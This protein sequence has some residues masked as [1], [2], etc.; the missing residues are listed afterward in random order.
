MEEHENFVRG[1][2][3]HGRDWQTIAE[4]FVPTRTP[5]QIRTHAQKY[6]KKLERAMSFS[7][8]VGS[9]KGMV[10]YAVLTKH[11][12]HHIANLMSGMRI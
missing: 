9:D 6:E 5:T 8:K 11:L 10:V 7:Q 1:L 4:R 2:E 12:P 3:A